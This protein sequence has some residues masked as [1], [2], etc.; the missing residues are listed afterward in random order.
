VQR[1]NALEELLATA[2]RRLDRAIET[3]SPPVPAHLLPPAALMAAHRAPQ[4]AQQQ[5]GLEARL[6]ATQAH[7]A[8]LAGE[9]ARQRDEIAA[10]VAGLQRN[11]ADLDGAV[12]K[13][14]GVGDDLRMETRALDEAVAGL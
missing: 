10:L 12:D 9:V 4:L 7:N 8:Q 3:D 6:R 2:R 13:L 14:A 11:V 1:L 5:R